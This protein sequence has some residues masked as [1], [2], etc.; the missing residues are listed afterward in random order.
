MHRHHFKH[1]RWARG[2]RRGE[3][4]GHESGHRHWGRGHRHGGGHRRMFEHGDLKILVLALLENEARHGYELIKEIETLSGG[5]YAPSPGVIYPLLTML[6]ELGLTQLEAL[7]GAK[8]R[9]SLTPDG[10]EHLAAKRS[11]SELLLRK[12]QEQ[13]QVSHRGRAPQIVRAMEN[14][15]LA[16]RLRMERGPMSDAQLQDVAAAIDAAAQAIERS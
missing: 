7:E 15:K 5:A 3:D 2:P 12:L 16:L 8:K 1:L 9:Y 13:Q 6:E 4:L 14:L 10:H 11:E